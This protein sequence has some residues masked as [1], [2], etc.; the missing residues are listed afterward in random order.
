MQLKGQTILITSG[1]T[2]LGRHFSLS[3]AKAGADVV[4]HDSSSAIQA[5]EINL[6]INKLG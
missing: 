5:Q 6:E 4:I 3:L 1:A 2:H